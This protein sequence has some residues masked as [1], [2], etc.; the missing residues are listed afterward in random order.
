MKTLLYFDWKRNGKQY[1]SNLIWPVVFFAILFVISIIAD[2]LVPVFNYKY[3]RWPDMVKDIIGLPA[4]CKSLYGNVW[5]LISIFYP[6]YFIYC[7]M[8]GLA[9]S[10]IEEERLETVVF[11]RNLSIQRNTLLITKLFVWIAQAFLSCFVLFIE[12]TVF[13]LCL[14][15]GQMVVSSFW[16]YMGLFLVC[17]LYIGIAVFLASYQKRETPCEDRIVGI[18]MIPFLIARIP[19]VIGFF[20]DLLEV[21]G[22]TGAAVSRLSDIAARLYSFNIVC[23]AVWCWQSSSISLLYVICGFLITMITLGM[24]YFIYTGKR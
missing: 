10:I 3:M 20:G 13:F 14:S 8:S 7:M 23:P 1:L 17:L 16:Y 4:W 9:G 22:R 19:A 12:N 21:T 2:K 5:Q 15:S 24:G 6:F 18:L 11:L